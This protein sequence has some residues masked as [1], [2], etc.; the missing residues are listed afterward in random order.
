M[1]GITVN[2]QL[3]EALEQASFWLALEPAATSAFLLALP[4][5]VVLPAATVLACVA[6]G[7]T[8]YNVVFFCQTKICGE[9]TDIT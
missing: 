9:Q 3:L 5:R 1:Y 8:K 2:V 7:C 6:F 4:G